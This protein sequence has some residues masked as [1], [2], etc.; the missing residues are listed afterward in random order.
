M[1]QPLACLLRLY[2]V[3]PHKV[4]RLQMS[5]L[6]SSLWTSKSAGRKKTWF[7][8]LSR[9]FFQ[10]S[11]HRLKSAQQLLYQLCGW[12]AINVTFGTGFISHF[13][14]SQTIRTTGVGNYGSLLS[15]WGYL[16]Q[17][18]M[19]NIS[20]FHLCLLFLFVSWFLTHAEMNAI[21]P[22]GGL[23]IIMK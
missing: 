1:F 3:F 16:L 23:L 19:F 15:K 6:W 4:F 2:L 11:R 9:I 18:W 13:R 8:T 21:M 7:T 20:F 12:S 17:I 10:K 14:I 5:L 22:G